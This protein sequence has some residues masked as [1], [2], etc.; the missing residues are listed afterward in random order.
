M[1]RQASTAHTRPL[2]PLF[3]KWP[4]KCQ[5]TLAPFVSLP[6]LSIRHSPQQFLTGN[7]AEKPE[8]GRYKLRKGYAMFVRIAGK[9]LFIGP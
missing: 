8:S 6:I 1:H 5:A 2:T 7:C 9:T 4:A 3:G